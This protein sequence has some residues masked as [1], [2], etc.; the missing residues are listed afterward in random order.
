MHAMYVF[1]YIL[2]SYVGVHLNTLLGDFF[3]FFCLFVL[4][5]ESTDTWLFRR[6]SVLPLY[7]IITFAPSCDFILYEN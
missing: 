2:F 1:G 4:I 3:S 6:I 7:G 5:F